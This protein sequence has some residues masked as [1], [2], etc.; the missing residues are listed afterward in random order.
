M[1]MYNIGHIILD[2]EDNVYCRVKGETSAWPPAR[3]GKRSMSKH[4]WTSKK[5]GKHR[6]NG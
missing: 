1:I 6:V 2:A 4:W 5:H 3:G